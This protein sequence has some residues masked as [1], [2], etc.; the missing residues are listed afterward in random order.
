[1]ADDHRTATAHRPSLGSLLRPATLCP[2]LLIQT[3]ADVTRGTRHRRGA[4]TRAVCPTA[5]QHRSC[6]VREGE[7][8]S[9]PADGPRCGE[10]LPDSPDPRERAHEAVVSRTT[11]PDD[12]ASLLA[13]LDLR[14]GPDG[15]KP[16]TEDGEAH[17]GR[18]DG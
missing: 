6:P 16:R 17:P 4:G 14:P 12:L 5:A 8:G 13:M 11:S 7:S 10:A 3:L 9:A 15:R 1:M 2:R 18:G